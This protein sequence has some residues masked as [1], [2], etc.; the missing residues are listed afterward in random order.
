MICFERQDEHTVDSD[1]SY[2]QDVF[3]YLNGDLIFRREVHR[4]VH[5][6]F[7]SSPIPS[8]VLLPCLGLTFFLLT[9][10]AVTHLLPYPEAGGERSEG[11]GGERSEGGGAETAPNASQEN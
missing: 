4:A 9:G 10:T 5:S 6:L 11:D 3:L 2:I 7:F 1:G 8:A